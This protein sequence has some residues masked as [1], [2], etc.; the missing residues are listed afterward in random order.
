MVVFCWLTSPLSLIPLDGFK[1]GGGSHLDKG[2]K[3]KRNKQ[4]FKKLCWVI[5]DIWKPQGQFRQ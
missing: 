4:S 3:R 2:I 5:M 1:F